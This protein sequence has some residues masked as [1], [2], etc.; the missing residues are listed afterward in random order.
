MF[1]VANFGLARRAGLLGAM[2]GYCLSRTAAQ[3]TRSISTSVTTFG[4]GLP[5]ALSAPGGHYSHAAAAGGLVFISGQLPVASD[6][7]KL[8][9]APFREQV[10][11]VLQNVD[12]ALALGGSSRS[13][14]V[15]VRVYI[16]DIA[17][18]AEFNVLY[19]AWLGENCRP[20][21]CVV[22]VPVLHYG[23][24][25]EVEAVAARV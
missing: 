9:G 21:R 4:G 17:L 20:A 12:S 11:A 1:V 16:T 14:L 15:S 5:G 13:Q 7:R 23:V 10:A 8:T 6:G 3:K 24:L 22:P 19:A 2:R 25:L 18:W